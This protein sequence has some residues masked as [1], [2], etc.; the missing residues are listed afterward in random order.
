[1]L[2]LNTD[3]HAHDQIAGLMRYAVGTARRGGATPDAV[4]NTRDYAGLR[5]WLDRSRGG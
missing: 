1:M 2:V 3:S 5:Q 4:L